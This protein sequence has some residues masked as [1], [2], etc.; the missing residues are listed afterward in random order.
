MPL[1]RMVPPPHEGRL[2]GRRKGRSVA[3]IQLHFHDNLDAFA[4]KVAVFRAIGE[5]LVIRDE[6]VIAF[7]IIGDERLAFEAAFVEEL[8]ACGVITA[9]RTQAMVRRAIGS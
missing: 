8:L 9:P 4:E 3:E 6:A 7:P 2:Q 5:E 1:S